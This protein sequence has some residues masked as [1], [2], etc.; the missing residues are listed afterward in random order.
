MRL[1]DADELYDYWLYNGENEPV[2]CTNDFLYSIEDA[3]TVNPV[4]H[5][6]WISVMREFGTNGDRLIRCSH[7]GAKEIRKYHYTDKFCRTCGAKM[8][9]GLK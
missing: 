5:S 2:Y 7:C 8:D 3:E 6:R 9:G 4:I 1:I